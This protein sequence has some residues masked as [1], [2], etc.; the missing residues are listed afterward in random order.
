MDNETEA[1]QDMSIR[2]EDEKRKRRMGHIGSILLLI[3]AI[4][5]G[6]AFVAQQK[7]MESV[8]PF[9]FNSVRS[10]VGAIALSP[11]LVIYRKKVFRIT[12]ESGEE[13]TDKGKKKA[14]LLSGVVS[15]G[16]IFFLATTSQQIGIG[17]TDNVGKAGFITAIYIIMVP[18]L[19]IFLG[20]RIP[21]I[22]WFCAL[23]SLSGFYFLCI[24]M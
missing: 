6:L 3:T 21:R 13:I 18:I 2:T 16:I 12:K 17:L 5:W 4:I 1:R 11:I 14:I 10:F 15:V 20:Q 9:T 23:L 7:G 8:G 22:I 24:R 19:S